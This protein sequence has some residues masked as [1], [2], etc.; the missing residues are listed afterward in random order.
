MACA[1]SF[2]SIL[3]KG[4]VPFQISTTNIRW[5]VISGCNTVTLLCFTRSVSMTCKLTV[6]GEYLPE[7]W[8][9]WTSFM[10]CVCV[11]WI[12]IESNLLPIFSSYYSHWLICNPKKSDY[13]WDHRFSPIFLTIDFI[14]WVRIFKSIIHFEVNYFC[15]GYGIK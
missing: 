11:C 6:D 2:W 9:S 1:L 3:Q 14:V 7:D 13:T 8:C 10:N 15:S 5:P 12:F 4:C